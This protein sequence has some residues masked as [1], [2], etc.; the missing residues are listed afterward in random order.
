MKK[1]GN[2]KMSNNRQSFDEECYRILRKVPKG[3]VTT[4]K[5]IADALGSKAYRAVGGAMNRNP[6]APKVPCHRVVNSDGTI[7]GFAS[8]PRAKVAILKKEGVVVKKN[9][10]QDFENLLYTF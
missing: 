2:I 8:G 3:R 4:Y 10:V 6:Y 7:G 1:I 9:K 5:A